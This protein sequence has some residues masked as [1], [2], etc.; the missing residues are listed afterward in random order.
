MSPWTVFTG[1]AWLGL[2]SIK[3]AKELFPLVFKVTDYSIGI[4]ELQSVETGPGL[5]D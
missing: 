4:E 5:L 3:T 1:T 2:R